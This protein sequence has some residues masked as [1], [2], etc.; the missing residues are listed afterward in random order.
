MTREEAISVLKETIDP[1][2][3]KSFKEWKEWDKEK[4]LPAVNMAIEALQAEPVK[5]GEWETGLLREFRDTNIEAQ[6]KADKAGYVRYVVNLKCSA[7]GKITMVDNSIKYNF[8]PNC[9]AKMDKD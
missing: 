8:C 1:N 9:G 4:H 5:H 3:D 7:C 6:E 2:V